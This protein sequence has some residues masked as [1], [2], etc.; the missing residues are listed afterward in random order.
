MHKLT[1]EYRKIIKRRKSKNSRKTT[2]PRMSSKINASVG[3]I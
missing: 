2:R 1:K 3:A